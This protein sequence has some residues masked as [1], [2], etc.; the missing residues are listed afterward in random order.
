MN[1]ENLTRLGSSEEGEVARPSSGFSARFAAST[2]P[3]VH[4]FF[5]RGGGHQ[6]G[7]FADDSL[8][9]ASVRVSWMARFLDGVATTSLF[10]LFFGLPLIFLSLSLQ[11][12]IFE[13]QMFFYFWLL[14]GLVGWVSKGIVTGELRIRRTP[15]D[16]PILLFWATVGISCFFSVDK[17]H[18]LWGFFGDPSRGFLN[19]TALTLAY[20]FISSHVNLK[21]FQIL[22]S[23][24]LLS[25]F[26]TAL[27]TGLVFL[28]VQF[29]PGAL[30][31]YAPLSLFGTVRSLTLFFGMLLP[32]FLL[33][34]T[35]LFRWFREKN[36]AFWS[37]AV[38]LSLGILLDLYVL[39]AVYAFTPW[40][41]VLI[42]V[43]FFLIFVLAQVVRF[44]ERLNW[45]PMALFVTVLVLLMI[46]NQ[47]S[48]FLSKKTTIFPEVALD[49]GS[50]W[51]ISK[52]SLK[53]RLM[54]GS[55]PATYGYDFSFYKPDSL[56]AVLQNN[57]RF[58]QSG[59][60]FLEILTTVGV[61]GGFFFLILVLTFLGVGLTGLSRERERN[62]VFSLG[63]W[64]TSLVFVVAIFR[65]PVEGPILVYGVLLL[66][67]AIPV[68]LEESGRDSEIIR[69][70]LKA[71]PKYALALAF[72]FMV[73]SAGV[74]FL[75]AFIWKAFLADM[76][77]GKASRLAAVEVNDEVLAAMGRAITLM[78][79]E[80]RYYV[81][82][83]Q[84]Y[85]SV[86]NKE[87]AKPESERDLDL[88]KRTVEQSAIPLVE[89]AR[90]LM[91]NDVLVQ[92]VAGQIYE[93]VSL[94]A[95]SDPDVLARTADVYHRALELE[96][97]NPTFY[98]KLGL[99]DR[100]LANRDEKKADRSTLLNEAKNYFSSAIEKKPDFI[101]GYLNRGLTEEALGDV[102][103]ALQDLEKANTIGPNSDVQ[104]NMVRML[105]IRG[106]DAD[107]DKAE[108]ISLG[109]LKSDSKNVNILFNLGFVYEK[110]KDKDK[111]I[112][113]YRKLLDVFGGDQYVDA[114][115]QINT[116][117]DNATSGKGNLAPAS[118]L[119]E[120]P[121]VAPT[122]IPPG[123]E[124]VS[125]T[126]PVISAPAPSNAAPKLPVTTT[127]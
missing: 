3:G 114:R 120:S 31:K 29:L 22:L 27:W 48:A 75:F 96:P 108:S 74:A 18:S 57:F 100:V 127:P 77:A 112:E 6:S 85:M 106:T 52:E 81:T 105:Q 9:T 14:L 17:W 107:L 19:V 8:A 39:L 35:L 92:E 80:G 123:A 47:G 103:A 78:P 54:M 125:N 20:F 7:S 38:A 21:R 89:E 65:M 69:L 122:E 45:M 59:N 11:G 28:G 71:S 64:A 36:W 119:K 99:I 70:S 86:V 117:I 82:L 116:L 50:S 51:T 90:T 40:F 97:K 49:Q 37:I 83:G 5:G 76:S 91:P 61:I 2:R 101:A 24:V 25:G 72:T 79:Y 56:N 93:N 30:L 66:A 88:I 121:S 26:L 63:I 15:L 23:G 115:K 118:S 41:S 104:F 84:M 95:G 12:L 44:G 109:V 46:G 68:L 53:A 43:S 1:N 87:A 16:V 126:A 60:L 32:L 94:L 55:G 98:V 67:L 34:F 111:A 102:P 10:M 73:V 4:S 62:K 113:T 58:Y 13:K 124:S 42:G 33:G 110:K